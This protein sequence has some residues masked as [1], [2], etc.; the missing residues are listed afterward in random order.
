MGIR[1]FGKLCFP[2]RGHAPAMRL[3]TAWLTAGAHPPWLRCPALPSLPAPR[4]PPDPDVPT[5]PPRPN[6]SYDGGVECDK[7]KSILLM[8]EASLV[9]LVLSCAPNNAPQHAPPS[10]AR[11]HEATHKRGRPLSDPA[12]TPPKPPFQVHA[13]AM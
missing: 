3:Q 5:G 7:P 1:R 2:P 12:G 11:P 10:H 6:L 4:L 8:R 13:R 9:S